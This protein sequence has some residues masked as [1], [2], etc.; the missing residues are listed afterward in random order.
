YHWVVLGVSLSA[1]GL[2]VLDW[3]RLWW[4]FPVGIGSY[5]FALSGYLAAKIRWE[6]WLSTH[7]SGQGGSYIAMTTAL[8]VVNWEYLTGVS[9][10][11]SPI[12]WA[13]PTLIGSPLIGRAVSRRVING[14]RGGASAR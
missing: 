11:R 12:A 9:G 13:L 1:C 8:L 2:S 10:I 14:L 7:I 3:N 5:A 6:G 4:F